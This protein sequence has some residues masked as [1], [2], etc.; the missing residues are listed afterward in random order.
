MDNERKTGKV[1]WFDE[2]K[3]WGFIRQ[4]DGPDV[5]VH[6]SD[7]VGDGWMLLPGDFVSFEVAQDRRGLRAVKVIRL[8]GRDQEHEGEL[9]PR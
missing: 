8:H 6:H 4:D 1:K 2:T 7:I 5:F 3:G 9:F